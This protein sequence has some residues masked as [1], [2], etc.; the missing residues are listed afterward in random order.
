MFTNCRLAAS[1]DYFY[2]VNVSLMKKIVFPFL[3]ILIFSNA[4]LAQDVIL[5]KDRY[6]FRATGKVYTGVFREYD[7][8]K[9]LL[10]ATCITNGLLED[11]TIIYFPAGNIK[12]IRS[13]KEGQKSGVWTTWNEA[14]KK[15]AEA[16]FKNGKKDG[17]WYVWDDQGVKRY[18]MFYMNGE[19]KGTW[20]IRDEKGNEI[21]RENFK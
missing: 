12:E 6:V 21:S 10:S 3:L 9:R 15:T 5:K 20:I 4:L 1:I 14:G 17:A 8:D 11:S 2:I 19:K 16:S 7:S 13:Y 18:E